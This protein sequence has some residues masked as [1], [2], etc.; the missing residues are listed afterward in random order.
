MGKLSVHTEEMADYLM[1]MHR[2]Y[3]DQE[4]IVR[5]HLTILDEAAGLLAPEDLAA[6]GYEYDALQQK[7]TTYVN[8]KMPPLHDT[9]PAAKPVNPYIE[10]VTTINRLLDKNEIHEFNQRI[11]HIQPFNRT[12]ETKDVVTMEDLLAGAGEIVGVNDL[13]RVFNGKDPFTGEELTLG[14]WAEAVGW[15]ALTLVPVAKAGKVGKV[16]KGT[17][18]IKGVKG[19]HP[20]EKLAKLG[21]ISKGTLQTVKQKGQDLTTE[22]KRQIQYFV[23]RYSN[24]F[25]NQLSPAMAGTGTK[26][27]RLVDDGQIYMYNSSGVTIKNSESVKGTYRYLKDYENNK[28]FTRSVEYYAGKDGTGFTYKIYQRSDINWDMVR[29]SGAKKGR[30][31]TN[32]EASTKYGLA[33]I[34]DD[35]GSVA[36]LHHSQQKGVGPLFEA[37]TRYH[38]ISNAK[39][40]PL[41]PYKGNLNPFYPMDDPTRKAFQKVDSINYWKMRGQEALGK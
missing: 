34:L 4:A 2:H 9:L 26:G 40:A 32:A 8:K 23:D 13:Y 5:R 27:V 30:G 31:L 41:H 11:R 16:A 37:S 39:K 1:R 10:A 36:T 19:L 7:G 24:M 14:E 17:K 29:T 20:S 38:N 22:G 25:G 18:K 6:A 12:T 33:P 35:A 21:E 28:Y 3:E 15:S